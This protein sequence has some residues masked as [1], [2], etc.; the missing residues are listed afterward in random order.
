MRRAALALLAAALLSACAQKV[1][2]LGPAV[3][4]PAIDLA[5]GASAGTL[6]TV[7]GQ[8]LPLRVFPAEGRPRAVM[9]VLHGLG[10][11]GNFFAIPAPAFAEAGITAYALDQR[12]H[13]AGP[14]PGEWSSAEAMVADARAAA[15]AVQ[16]RHPGL[17]FFLYGHSM[18]GGIALL[19]VTDNAV[20]RAVGGPVAV[21]GTVLEAPSVFGRR[22]LPLAGRLG[23]FVL[24][25]TAPGLELDGSGLDIH[26]SDN[27][28]M[29]QAY[30]ADP[31]TQK[32]VRVDFV[33]GFMD[34]MDEA[35]EAAPALPPPALILLAEHEEV[36]DAGSVDY[37]RGAVA[38][39]GVTVEEV[40][41]S[42]H[43]MSRG[44]NRDAVLAKALAWIDA[45]LPVTPTRRGS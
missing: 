19:T 11:Y 23:L 27:G 24:R 14:H 37:L 28:P 5:Q 42:W 8:A 35:V 33:A 36:L 20:S 12:G 43:M 26:P 40:P 3:Q 30:S 41:D 18:G 22:F 21:A 45:H 2:P 9:L 34:T 38:K 29:L 15:L 13:G 44:L 17:P 1:H 6:R 39:P 7:D 31:L 25:R 32:A 16:A 10:D 4:Q